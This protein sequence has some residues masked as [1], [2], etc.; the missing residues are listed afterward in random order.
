M[1]KLQEK[2]NEILRLNELVKQAEHEYEEELKKEEN[3]FLTKYP[4][5]ISDYEIKTDKLTVECNYLNFQQAKEEQSKDVFYLQVEEPD[6]R[7]CAGLALT[8]DTAKQ[9]SDYLLKVINY[10]EDK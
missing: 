4:L 3:W 5:E 1:S 6:I 10:M 8:L 7:Q 9:L 2:M